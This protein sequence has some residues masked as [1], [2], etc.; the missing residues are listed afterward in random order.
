MIHWKWLSAEWTRA[1]I[2]LVRREQFL[3]V[4][5]SHRA[6]SPQ[7]PMHDWGEKSEAASEYE[8]VI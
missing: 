5:Q 3:D 6:R 1:L 7:R 4:V 2:E 8:T